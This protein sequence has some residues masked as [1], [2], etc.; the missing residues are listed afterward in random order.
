MAVGS[1]S[2]EGGII[3][4]SMLAGR[5]MAP[6]GQVAGLIMQ[7]PH[8]KSGLGAVER[9]MKVLR[10]LWEHNPEERFPN[11]SVPVL[12]MP[13]VGSGEAAWA[14]GRYRWPEGPPRT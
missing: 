12:F 11:I 13:A 7:Y 3:A 9:H 1:E 14:R 6:F 5:A 2:F 8:A 10:G 4:A